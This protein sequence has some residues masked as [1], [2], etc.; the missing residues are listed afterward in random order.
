MY[1]EHISK[2]IIIQKYIKGYLIRKGIVIQNSCYQTKEWRKNK[3][4]YKNGKYNEYEKYQIES[5]EKLIGIKLDKTHDRINIEQNKI[6]H[7]KHPNVSNDGYEW[8]ENF[9]GK[10]MVLKQEH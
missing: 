4:W 10:I 3:I 2:I 5:I 9:D 8:T 1:E 6:L 7:N